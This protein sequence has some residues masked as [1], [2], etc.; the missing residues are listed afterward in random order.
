MRRPKCGAESTTVFIKSRPIHIV[1]LC[2]NKKDLIADTGLTDSEKWE[3][4]WNSGNLGWDVLLEPFLNNR[5]FRDHQLNV[6][7]LWG[8]ETRSK[9]SPSE[10]GKPVRMFRNNPT[11]T[12]LLKHQRHCPSTE[13]VSTKKEVP[14][15]S[16]T[17][18]CS[19]PHGQVLH[20]TA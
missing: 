4:L 2:Q 20:N 13:R 1:S 7:P 17:E 3:S 18:I 6:S 5:R 14:P 19:I 8:S 10:E 11:T 15:S 12:K 9:L 16:L